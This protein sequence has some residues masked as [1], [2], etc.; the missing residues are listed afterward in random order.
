MNAL[1]QDSGGG[2][3]DE[4]MRKYGL[5]QYR[6]FLSAFKAL[7]LCAVVE[8]EIFV[9]HGGL[10]RVKSLSIDYI[11]SIEHQDCTA[12]HPMAT[13]IKDQVFSDLL[14]SD[15]TDQPGKFKSERGIG[16][17]FGQDITTKFCMQNRL[18]FIIRSH[19]LPEDGRGYM[20]QHEGR[21][22]TIFSA[23]NYCGDGGNYGAVLVLDSQHFPKYEIIEHYAAPL[24]D[25]P[26]L[27]GLS[28]QISNEQQKAENESKT[29]AK[30]W[31]RE[32]GRMITGIIDKKPVL[33]AHLVDMSL[34]NTLPCDDW[35]EMM[36]EFVEGNH[37][38]KE[39]AS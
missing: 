6:R 33:W 3:S 15:P 36:N 26:H 24:E 37:P 30:R 13:N 23:S 4:V 25:M 14:W 32:L 22:V 9:V 10:T 16:I 8:K 27:L 21:C 35:V 31:E 19:Q 2:F 20:K 18:R 11:N 39:A 17:K 29:R 12:P 28:T 7:G 34:P 1:D 38:W 5:V